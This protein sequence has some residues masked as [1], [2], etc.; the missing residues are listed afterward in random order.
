MAANALVKSAM[1]DAEFQLVFRS[2]LGIDY[3]KCR[4]LCS[5]DA[6]F[7]NAISDGDKPGWLRVGCSG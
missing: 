1:Q 4:I 2:D 5:S 3:S 6:A 7:A